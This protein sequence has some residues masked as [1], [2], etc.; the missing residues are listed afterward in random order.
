VLGGAISSSLILLITLVVAGVLAAGLMQISQMKL[1]EKI[2]Q[3]IFA[4]YAFDISKRLPLLDMKKADGTYLPE[5]VNRF[6]ETNNLQK[7]LSKL[8]L[9]IPTASI[10][11][12]SGL[13]L[14]S[15]YHP[16]FIFFGL[17][18]M[19][20]LFLILYLSGSKGLRTSMEESKYKYAVAAWLEEMARVIRSFK[21]AGGSQIHMQKTNE[22]VMGYLKARTSH[23]RIL[24]VQFRV[25][26]VFKVIITASMLFVGALLLVDQQ[27]N[28]GQ[29]IAA[30]I[31]IITVI[32]SVEKLI[33]NLDSVYDVLTS[34]DKLAK[35]TDKEL[36][37][38]GSYQMPVT[39][40]GPS[41]EIQNVSFG[42]SVDDAILKNIS[43]KIK[44]GEKVAITGKGGSGKSTLLRLFTGAYSDF[45]GAVLIDG[46]P[47]GNYSLDSLRMQTG[48]FLGQ[49]DI[50][51]GTLLENI[52]MGN[53]AI[54]PESI[55]P[56]AEKT[57]LQSFIGTLKTG[58]DTMLDPT[59]NRLPRSVVQKILLTRALVNKPGLLLLEEPWES[60]EDSYRQRIQQLLLNELPGV[61]MLVIASDEAFTK[62]C[63]RVIHLTKGE[64]DI[65]TN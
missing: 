63:D 29:F 46:I 41:L 61:T 42:Y 65:Q 28:I 51:N 37:A 19:F 57:G 50:F 34:V 17:L 15:F 7:S 22:N 6:F 4:R 45:K 56:L 36:E 31:V 35:I 14:L 13:V 21:F 8:L 10:Q 53:P 58:F 25:L 12:L 48:V 43:F 23:F 1:I 39:G 54:T 30:E 5:L 59:G 44:P 52:S 2:Q 24:L 11:I 33:G 38:D 47:V 64:A 27:L 9:D 32:N 40:T 55:R 3:K 20:L 62:K 49:Q 60:Q 26:V 16:A 18:L